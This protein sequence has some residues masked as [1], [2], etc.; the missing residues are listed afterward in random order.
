MVIEELRFELPGEDVHNTALRRR[1]ER[2]QRVFEQLAAGAPTEEAAAI[3]T[4]IA[5]ARMKEEEAEAYA[6]NGHPPK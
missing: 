6:H 4:E 1:D 2:E 3:A 5:S